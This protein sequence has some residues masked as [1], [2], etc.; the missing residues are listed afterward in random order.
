[1][2]RYSLLATFA[3]TAGIAFANAPDISKV[4]GSIHL[5]AAHVGGIET[6]NGH[7]DIGARSRVEGGI[8]VKKSCT[9]G[10]WT[11]SFRADANLHG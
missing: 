9:Q 4:N 2:S 11:G 7:I 3:L 5:D 10:F 1:M 6:V 8:L